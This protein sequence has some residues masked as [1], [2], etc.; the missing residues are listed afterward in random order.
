MSDRAAEQNHALATLFSY[1]ALLLLTDVFENGII[2]LH[3]ICND[4]QLCRARR[5]VD[6]F[7]TANF[8]CE[9]HDKR[10]VTETIQSTRNTKVDV[11]TILNEKRERRAY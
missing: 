3:V 10:D 7:R 1:L 6:V 8:T 5:F 4:I 2:Y 9:E 11:T